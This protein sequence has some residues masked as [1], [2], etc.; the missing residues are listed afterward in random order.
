MTAEDDFN[1]FE[2]PTLDAPVVLVSGLPVFEKE[3]VY[4]SL[5][6]FV[7]S[8]FD[9]VLFD[10]NIKGRVSNL[11]IFG[12]DFREEM[13]E[14]EVV[15]EQKQEL[16]SAHVQ[17]EISELNQKSEQE[18]ELIQRSLQAQIKATMM[19]VNLIMDQKESVTMENEEL[20]KQISHL[21]SKARRKK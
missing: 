20:N 5:P 3:F 19:E 8:T 15:E 18:L 13:E 12:I 7:P 10:E 11:S 6:E 2:A 16:V 21:V 1:D 17:F 14:K 9:N 4:E